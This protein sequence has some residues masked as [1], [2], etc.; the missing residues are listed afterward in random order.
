MYR[1]TRQFVQIMLD[2]HQQITGEELSP[3]DLGREEVIKLYPVASAL[4]QFSADLVRVKNSRHPGT[5]NE[6][7]LEEHLA[8]KDLPARRESLPSEGTLQFP[9]TEVGV[10]IPVGTIA[11]HGLTGNE[12]KCISSDASEGGFVTALFKSSLK[13]QALNIDKLNQGFA[14]ADAIEGIEAEGGNISVFAKGRDLET[15]AEMLAR[16]QDH[17]RKLD[18]G[19]NIVAYERLAKEASPAVVTAT[20][21]KHARGVST[22]DVVIT[23]GTTNIEEAV[24]NGEAV[25]RTPSSELI[26]EVEE[27]VNDK[28][29]TTDDFKAV[30]PTELAFSSTVNYELFDLTELERVEKIIN[31]A[32]KVFVLTARPGK[33]IYTTTLERQIDQKVASSLK[34]LRVDNFSAGPYFDVPQDKLLLPDVLTLNNIG[35]E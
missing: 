2:R 1:T 3:D 29:P 8:A 11:T 22:M 35:G 31:Y 25:V 9:A 33:R 5:S 7:D 32:W 23:S 34:Y 27:Y 13:G 21:I 18:T 15:P 28:K 6:F 12:Y 16:I 17:D 26:A 20:A 4:S 10:S 24:A 14:L 30:A 19:G